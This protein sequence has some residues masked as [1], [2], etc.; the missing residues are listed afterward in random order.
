MSEINKIKII[1][2]DIRKIYE[3]FS[4]DNGM[5]RNGYLANLK[6][7]LAE[8]EKL[9]KEYKCCQRCG[10]IFADCEVEEVIA[11]ECRNIKVY[12]TLKRC[13]CEKVNIFERKRVGDC[14]GCEKGT[15]C[16]KLVLKFPLD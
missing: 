5:L 9:K 2:E 6:Q 4:S 13:R 16:F 7:L 8:Y 1:E 10:K 15:C 14:K 11:Y 3:L 12:F